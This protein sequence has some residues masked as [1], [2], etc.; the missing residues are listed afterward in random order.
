MENY[1][2]IDLLD[3]RMRLLS[4]LNNIDRK[5]LA[6][7]TPKNSEENL[8]FIDVDGDDGLTIPDFRNAINK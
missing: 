1:Q 4:R 6:R 2:K 3:E 8:D 7:K 5:H